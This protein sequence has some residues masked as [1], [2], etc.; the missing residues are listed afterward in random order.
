VPKAIKYVIGD[1]EVE[2]LRELVRAKTPFMIVGASAAILQ[3]YD[4]GTKDIDLWF[5]STSDV[6]LDRAA[7]KMG[8]MFIWRA[9]PPVLS[10]EALVNF[11]VV[12]TMHGLGSFKEEYRDAIDVQVDDFTVKMLPLDRII[13]SKTVADR[14]KDR[15]SLPALKAA[16]AANHYVIRKRGR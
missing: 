4:G 13:A 1:Q 5:A 11:D 14:D 16:L 8:G 3:G 6:G 15:A 7:R 10:G 12:N 2:F 9:N